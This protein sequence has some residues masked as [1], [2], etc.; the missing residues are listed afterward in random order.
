MVLVAGTGHLLGNWAH[1][2]VPRAGMLGSFGLTVEHDRFRSTCRLL[3]VLRGGGGAC[4]FAYSGPARFEIRIRLRRM[5]LGRRLCLGRF[6]ACAL[7]LLGMKPGRLQRT[8]GRPVIRF[9]R[10][11]ADGR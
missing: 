8:L 6:G 11:L 2:G 9:G 3:R 5:A 10:L 4:R 1:R 7:G